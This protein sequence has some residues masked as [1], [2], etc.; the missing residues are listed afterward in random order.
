MKWLKN[1]PSWG[2]VTGVLL[3]AALVFRFALRG[4]SYIA[5]TLT[6][7]AALIVMHR[8]FSR[9]LWRIVVILVCIGLVYFIIVEVPIIKNA[10]T[11]PEPERPYLIVLGAAVHGDYP[12]LSLVHRLQGALEYLEEYPDSRAIVSGGQGVGENL[13]EAQSMFDWLT[14]HGIA[15]ER[16]IMEDMATSTKENLLFSFEIIEALGDKPE[17]SVAILSSPYH[18]YRAKSMAKILGVDAV[19]VA[20][21]PDYPVLTINYFI[22]EA[23]GVTHLWVFGW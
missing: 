3:A 4:Y 21:V 14:A 13:T 16:I 17:G 9:T 2:L 6:F 20:G 19:G 18:L 22:R 15:P 11:D 8:Y 23:F 10:H 7:I 5:H 1:I 12:S